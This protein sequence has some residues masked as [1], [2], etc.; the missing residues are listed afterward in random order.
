MTNP[1][2]KF[3]VAMSGGVDSSTVAAM[4][5]HQGHEVIGVTL[6]LYESNTMEKGVCCTGIDDAKNVAKKLDIPHHVLNCER[7]FKKSVIDDFADTYLRGETPI[8]CIHC[9]QDIKFAELFKMAKK[10]KADTVATGHYV[11]KIQNAAKNELHKAV[12][13]KKDQSYFLF[14]TTPEQLGF[15]EFPLGNFSKEYTRELAQKYNL[16]IANK[17]DSQDICFVSGGD[18]KKIIEKFRPGA[19]D[20]G[21]ILDVKGNLIGKHDGIINYTVGQ[22]KGLGIA[23]KEPY[24]V[25]K[26]NPKDNSVVIGYEKDLRRTEFYIK[27]TNW[28]IDEDLVRVGLEAEVKLRST[29]KGC[30]AKICKI[31]KNGVYKIRLSE[32]QKSITPGQACVFYEGSRLLGGGW[33]T[34]EIK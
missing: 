18:Y 17:P 2:R 15:L 4:L 5:K 16:E 8:P 7:K 31:S 14:T 33:I 24:Y 6:Q 11:R 10:L 20:P 22:R 19:L 13:D 25:I 27:D 1:K 3:I 28:L 26:I 21:N 23:A 29:H 34:S 12:D 30:K 9:N 32:Y